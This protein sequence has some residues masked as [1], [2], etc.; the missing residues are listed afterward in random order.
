MEHYQAIEKAN[1]APSIQFAATDDGIQIN[2][3]TRAALNFASL[4]GALLRCYRELDR[5]KPQGME[6][7][8]FKVLLLVA[9]GVFFEEDPTRNLWRVDEFVAQKFVPLCKLLGAITTAQ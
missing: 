9:T 1:Y 4:H 5:I 3:F 2:E 8:T 7:E 6:M